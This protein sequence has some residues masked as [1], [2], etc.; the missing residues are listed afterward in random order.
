M[1]QSHDPVS[2]AATSAHRAGRIERARFTALAPAAARALAALA[3][4]VVESGFDTGLAELVKVRVSQMNGCAFCVGFH[5][6]LARKA[7][8]EPAKLDLLAV[9]RDAPVF[10]AR[11]RAALGWAE[12]LTL[13]TPDAEGDAA[14]AGMREMFD[15]AELVQLTVVVATIN[16]WNR[17]AGPLGFT[18]AAG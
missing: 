13:A 7:G 2:L 9:W 11:E 5:L 3:A 8:V 14:R 1:T 12:Q 16:A 10:S 15:E 4:S 18:P 6:D 17:I